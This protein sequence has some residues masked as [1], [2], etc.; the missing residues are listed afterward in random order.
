[1]KILKD[2]ELGWR[3]C[4]LYWSDKYIGFHFP[5]QHGWKRHPTW[6]KG[7]WEYFEPAF[8]YGNKT[9]KYSKWYKLPHI[10]IPAKL[11]HLW[12]IVRHKGYR[13]AFRE[14]K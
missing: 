9:K 12:R 5:L 13:E 3:D 10:L 4:T 14:D 11:T 7:G 1:M 2:D 6:I 8:I